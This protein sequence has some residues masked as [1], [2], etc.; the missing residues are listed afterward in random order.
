MCPYA[1]NVQALSTPVESF[2]KDVFESEDSP[3]SKISA[4]QEKH[5]RE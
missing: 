4:D 3:G 2:D 1:G 5:V